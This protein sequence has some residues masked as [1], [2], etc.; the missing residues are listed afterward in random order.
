MT[1]AI[2]LFFSSYMTKYLNT[3]HILLLNKE[4]IGKEVFVFF[5]YLYGSARITIGFLNMK[6]VISTNSHNNFLFY[7]Q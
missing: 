2:Y 3:Q 5:L 6:F 1:F 4:N 7:A